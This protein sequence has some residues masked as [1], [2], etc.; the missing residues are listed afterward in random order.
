MKFYQSNLLKK[1]S[2]ITHAFTTK[3][4]GNLALHVNDNPS[5]VINNHKYLATELNYNKKELVY[6]K[7]IHSDI[8][9]IVNNNDNFENPPTCDA[10]ITNQKNTP[11]MVMVADCSPIIFYD[12]KKEVIAVAHAGRKGAF[13]NIINNVIQSF[14]N[15]F[16]SDI[17]DIVVVIGASIKEC[18]YEV[19]SEIYNEA[20]KLNLEYSIQKKD[21]KFYLNIS[22]ILKNQLFKVGINEKNI[23]ISNECSCCNDSKYFSY[24][25]NKNTGRFAGVILLK[26]N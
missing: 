22:K 19:G 11:L 21:N 25:A 7:Q 5:N 23:E 6:M 24:R 12:S 13:E 17:N 4:S 18:C 2:N 8:V 9:H 16:N 26:N 1:F 15:D 14:L 10:L 20:N 3:E